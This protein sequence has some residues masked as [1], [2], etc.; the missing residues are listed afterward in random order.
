MRKQPAFWMYRQYALILTK[1]GHEKAAMTAI[2]KSNEL[3]QKVG[4]KD[5]VI[6]N[7]ASIAEWS[8]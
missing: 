1:L 6:M 7:N 4:N 5:Y 3:A 2:I 8:K